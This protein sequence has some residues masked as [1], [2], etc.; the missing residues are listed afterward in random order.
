[1]RVSYS[2]CVCK[3]KSGEGS[4]KRTERVKE[5]LEDFKHT[6]EGELARSHH[7]RA[8]MPVCVCVYAE[9]YVQKSLWAIKLR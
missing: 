3:A 5:R 1:V 7:T 2:V 9:M 4:S 6:H 8:D